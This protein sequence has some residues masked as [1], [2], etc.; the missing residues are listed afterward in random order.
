MDYHKIRK[1]KTF[2]RIAVL[3]VPFVLSSCL[4]YSVDEFEGHRPI[5]VD[6]YA[7][8]PTTELSLD[9]TNTELDIYETREL[10]EELERIQVQTPWVKKDFVDYHNQEV[11]EDVYVSDTYE[12]QIPVERRQ[13]FIDLVLKQ[14]RTALE[15]YDEKILRKTDWRTILEDP[16]NDWKL[17]GTVTSSNTPVFKPQPLL[18]NIK[19]SVWGMMYI[20]GLGASCIFLIRELS[21]RETEFTK[22][23]E[24]FYEELNQEYPISEKEKKRLKR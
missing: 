1:L 21:K 4:V 14:D 17:Y 5:I 13:E 22:S 18:D 10:G 6:Q 2:K 12:Y 7:F 15:N 16:E 11:V 23:W 3:S 8:Y 19:D 20:Y 9:G 24:T